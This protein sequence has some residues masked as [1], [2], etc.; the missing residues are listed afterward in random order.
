MSM[1]REQI[2]NFLMHEDMPVDEIIG[3]HSMEEVCVEVIAILLSGEPEPI[4][5]AL[6]FLRDT[7]T[8][9]HRFSEA[10]HQHLQSSPIWETLRQLLRAPNTNVRHNAINT[11]GKLG[12]RE[13]VSLLED[14]FPY[15][16]ERDP[17]NL[18]GLMFELGWLRSNHHGEFL[19]RIARANHPLARWSLCEIL[20]SLEGASDQGAV[21]ELASLLSVDPHPHVAAQAAWAC[22]RI[23]IKL[24]PKLPKP[25]WR[26]EVK[27]IAALKPQLTYFYVTHRFMLD[28]SDYTLAEFDTHFAEIT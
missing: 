14:A 9:Q 8:Y 18:P 1:L 13:R 5:H 19:E 6:V 7:A 16:L 22:E 27:R 10:F 21:L 12:H 11:I 26:K 20:Q 2:R 3:S 23:K 17:I 24:G 15:F 28:R 25:E 4:S